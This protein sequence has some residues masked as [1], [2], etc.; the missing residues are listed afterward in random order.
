MS[1]FDDVMAEFLIESREGLDHLDR[2]LVALE[3]TPGDRELL[4]RI[5]RCFHTIKGTSGFLGFG[6][7]ENLTHAGENLL[8]RLRE[9][10]L[11][12][13]GD[14]TSALLETLDV[15]RNML[16]EVEAC[17]ND[18]DQDYAE[19]ADKLRALCR[20]ELP[21][22]EAVAAKV[23]APEP[24]PVAQA[25]APSE[26]P[27]APV[28]DH[29]VAAEPARADAA[30]GEEVV[31]EGHKAVMAENVRV[32]VALLDSLVDLA[33]ELV[34][35][36]NH[37]I[38]LTKTREDAE[39]AAVTQRLNLVTAQLQ[40]GIMR[41]RMQPVSSMFTKFPRLVRDLAR[42]C[43]KQVRLEVDGRDAELDK[44][45]LE[46]IKDPLTHLLRN[47]VDHGIESPEVR[48][49]KGKHP[50]GRVSL[51]SY[52]Q[53]GLVH[54]EVSDDGGGIPFDKV[55]D[56]AVAR[57]LLSKERAAA[58]GNSEVASLIFMPGFSTAEQVTNVSGRGVGMDVVKT[59]VEQIGGAVQVDSRAGLGTTFTLKIPLTL[60]I[61]PA[62]VIRAGADR[63]A[64]PQVNVLELV[65]LDGSSERPA[66]EWIHG[67]PVY[68][69]RDELLPVVF[70]TEALGGCVTESD[71]A[72]ETSNL[73]EASAHH[74]V[75][76][77][78]AG[79]QF[80][81]VVEAVSDQQEIVVKPLPPLLAKVHAF[82][83]A[84][85]L[86]DG[87][88]ALIL[89]ILAI[90]ERAR[91]I[92]A[93]RE[94]SIAQRRES[95]HGQAEGQTTLLLLR[96]KGDERLAVP[97]DGIT[98]LETI[99][100][101]AIEGGGRHEVVQYRGQIMPLLHAAQLL[102]ERRARRRVET[103]TSPAQS[104]L[105]SVVVYG[106]S[107]RPIGLVV[108]DVLDVVDTCEQPQ[109]LGCRDGVKGTLV[110]QERVTEVIDLR[111]IT[112]AAG[113][114]YHTHETRMVG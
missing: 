54:I 81:L 85:L 49:A 58:L 76:L 8:S 46:A 112:E 38:Q 56:K 39:L 103:P 11:V 70:L 50:E 100:V 104:K 15:V 22:Q 106:N 40:T 34:L 57:G 5:F 37:L 28:D 77:Q 26:P 63:Y 62:L 101:D 83:G 12:A 90:A 60:A 20:G 17:G 68:R 2:D 66:L 13:N 99:D 45:L 73:K 69:L 97:L 78:G 72:R 84:T 108:D 82:A 98:R 3:E 24:T 1:D 4:A 110:V 105:L 91:V 31:V 55:R 51:R 86:G 44:S 87:R 61:V 102:P 111:W 47:C 109:N 19:L 7:L 6:K 107:D 23:A 32:D 16:G 96:G 52:H 41:M 94:E 42:T 89:D 21:A 74:L 93:I 95:I 92:S 35:T 48:I 43:K 114:E 27:A 33:G 59:N 30:Q 113:L 36:R 79:R 71:Y 9:G 75:V 18:G 88:V 29:H 53:N 14:I 65:R 25:V 80:G 64:I 10:E 67:T